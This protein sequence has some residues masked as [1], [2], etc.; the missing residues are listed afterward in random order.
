M[1]SMLREAA[2][3]ALRGDWHDAHNIVQQNETELANW[4]HAVLHKIEGDYTNSRYW[5][6]RSGGRQFTD[7]THSQAELEAILMALEAN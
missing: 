7:F 2:L 1:S 4:L 6:A 3:A 5:Y